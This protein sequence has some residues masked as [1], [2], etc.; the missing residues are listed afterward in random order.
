MIHSWLNLT[1]IY[2]Q[3]ITNAYKDPKQE[4][5]RITNPPSMKLSELWLLLEELWH[6]NKKVF[7]FSVSRDNLNIKF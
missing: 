4:Q 7:D 2:S 5:T 1:S 3:N 6:N